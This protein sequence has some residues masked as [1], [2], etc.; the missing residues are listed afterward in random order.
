MIK[1]VLFVAV[2]LATSGEVCKPSYGRGVGTIP[3]GC[4]DNA[5]DY[6]A[7][8]CYIECKKGYDAVGPVCWERCK[9]EETDDGA[10]CRIPLIIV[11]KKSY[12]RGVGT[13]PNQCP[14]GKE[15]Q[16]GL[17]YDRCQ[18]GYY[19]AG[20]VCW[21]HCAS[22]Y[23]DH[24]ATCYKSI[25]DF[26][27][28]KS[29]GRG[30]GTIPDQCPAGQE[31]QNG[32][33]YNRCSSGYYGEGPVCWEICN[34]IDHGT[35][36][37]IQ[38]LSTR[39]KNSYGRGAG[40][41]RNQC[42]NEEELDTGLC[43][44]YCEDH[45]HGIGPVCWNNNFPETAQ[46]VAA[47]APIASTL[48]TTCSLDI[49]YNAITDAIDFNSLLKADF[50]DVDLCLLG[51]LVE[52]IS[53]SWSPEKTAIGIKIALQGHIVGGIIGFLTDKDNYFGFDTAIDFIN[54]Y[55]QIKPNDFKDEEISDFIFEF[56]QFFFD[57]FISTGGFNIY[58]GIAF[59]PNND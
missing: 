1:S 42:N 13:I 7:G 27:G 11:A 25:I 53:G 15:N 47:S 44:K 39:A 23:A 55:K 2:I 26:Y 4:P 3:Q 51:K 20:P 38:S 5:P 43:Y 49:V 29:Y 36:C 17:C 34:G 28:K 48:A 59:K 50:K 37:E 35:L 10:F 9:Q 41:I 54:N 22:G 33:C 30:A 58:I 21:E 6:D 57:N 14:A 19:A 32:L 45:F 8:L 12:G 56:L 46:I 31:N 40:V 16:D 24:G 18:S 52:E